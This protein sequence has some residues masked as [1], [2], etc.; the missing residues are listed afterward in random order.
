MGDLQM[1]IANLNLA[2]GPPL[3]SLRRNVAGSASSLAGVLQL[4]LMNA[5]SLFRSLCGSA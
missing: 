5:R 4:A 3:P 2:F 1:M